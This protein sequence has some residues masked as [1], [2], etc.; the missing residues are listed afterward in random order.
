MGLG[1][2]Q[3]IHSDEEDRAVT[4]PYWFFVLVTV[5]APIRAAFRSA[6][7]TRQRNLLAIGHCSFC[8]YDLWAS[9]ERCSECGTPITSR[10]ENAT[11]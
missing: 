1:C 3:A 5:I 2:W 10:R 11:A 6:R 4:A 8:G 9:M 7:R